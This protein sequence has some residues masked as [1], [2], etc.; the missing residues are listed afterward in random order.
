MLFYPRPKRIVINSEIAGSATVIP[1]HLYTPKDLPSAFVQDQKNHHY[2]R[3]LRIYVKV[4]VMPGATT[5]Q[6]NMN[7]PPG[8]LVAPN[9]EIGTSNEYRIRKF[10]DEIFDWYKTAL[11][12][13]GYRLEA[14]TAGHHTQMRSFRSKDGTTLIWVQV[15]PIPG[16]MNSELSFNVEYLIPVGSSVRLNVC[17]T[18]TGKYQYIVS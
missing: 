12:Q 4:P 14:I 15:T 6:E 17:L 16:T 11:S 18:R 5:S 10:P 13:Q 2:W 1:L 3:N 8:Y 9:L 7:E